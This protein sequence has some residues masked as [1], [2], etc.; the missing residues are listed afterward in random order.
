MPTTVAVIVKDALVLIQ[1]QNPR[2]PVS[3]QD[4]TDGIRALNRMV[5]RWEA[6]GTS[7]GWSP[8]SNPGDVLPA[9]DEAEEAIV[10]NLAIRLA[11]QFGA[12]VMPEVAGPAM[13]FYADLLRDQAVATPMRAIV[14]APLAENPV[15]A[16]F[17]SPAFYG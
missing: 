3:A 12:T 17:I 11:P 15:S 6:D 1:A 16:D 14:A 9:P 7:L 2:Q 8:V 5:Q 4:M 13:S 10:Y